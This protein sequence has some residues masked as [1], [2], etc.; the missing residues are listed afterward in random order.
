[1]SQEKKKHIYPSS[2]KNNFI[3]N[4]KKVEDHYD[5]KLQI[6]MNKRK[7]SEI[8]GLRNFNNWV[9]NTLIQKYISKGD[10][11]LDLC[12][13]KGGDLN[14]F[15]K[16]DI[17]VLYGVDIS[18]ESLK[19]MVERYQNSKIKYSLKLYHGD[20]TTKN[21]NI[22]KVDV[23]SCQFALHYSFESEKQ[24]RRLLMN[25]EQ[26]LKNGGYFL[27]TTTDSY[28]MVKKLNEKGLK[29]GNE[30][31]QVEFENSSFTQGYGNKYTFALKEAIDSCP[32]YLVHPKIFESLAKEYG[33]DL[34][35]NL[36][37]HE[38]YEKFYEPFSYD[39]SKDEW[40]CIYLYKVYVFQ[41]QGEKKEKEY[42]PQKR[43]Y[44]IEIISL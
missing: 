6:G 43:S 40:D 2:L 42:I 8:I 44:P 10:Q 17:S 39:I 32:E 15:D 35:L 20:A 12:C 16:K 41:K 23:V 5:N 24:A 21:I 27:V 25:V 3:N 33:L 19:D 34:I 26:N 28:V 1:M 36:N 18:K 29:Y 14:K 38:F 7:D 11:V 22:A 13:G 31:Y 4:A 9:K 37:F 30:I